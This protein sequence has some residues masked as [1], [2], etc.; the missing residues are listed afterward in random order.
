MVGPARRREAVDNVC[1]RLEVSERRAC[2]TLGQARSSQRYQASPREDDARLTAAIRR[3]AAREPRAGYRG[4]RRHLVREGWH[5]NLKRVHRIWKKEGLRVPPQAHRKRRMGNAENGTQRLQAERINHVWSYDFV[6]DRTE[7]GGR[8]KWLPVIDEFTRECLSL[9]VARSMT[10]SD[11]IETLDRLVEEYGIPDFIRSDNGP[12]FV[13]RAV[14]DWIAARGFR[15]LFIEPGS[16]WQNCFIE[17]FNARFRDGFLNVESFTSL[18]EAKVLSAEHR[19][20]YNHRRPHSSLGDLTPA[21][22]AAACLN[23]PGCFQAPFA[24][25]ELRTHSRRPEP[26]NNPPTPGLAKRAPIPDPEAG[27]PQQSEPE[28]STHNEKLS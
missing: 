10:S 13:A 26:G 18:L 2:R 11:V 25:D 15:T 19:D 1:Q 28:E 12:E 24:S 17:S 21:E 27:K 6:F 3:I 20:R 9:D 4:V 8:L 5:V 7:W 22:F 23:P 16:P 14:K